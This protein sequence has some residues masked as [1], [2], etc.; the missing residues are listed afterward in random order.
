MFYS[1]TMVSQNA[2]IGPMPVSTVSNST[3]PD[4]CPLKAKGCYA[5]TGPLALHWKK[6]TSGERGDS[7]EDFVQKVRK[8]PHGIWRYAQAGDLPGDGDK[9]DLD[10]LTLLA[11]ANRG[12]PV[13][14]YTHKP[15]TKENVAALAAANDHG[16]HINISC[17]TLDKCDEAITLGFSAAVVVHSQYQRGKNEDLDD[18]KARI[19]AA[20]LRTPAGNKVAICPATYTDT[21][22]LRCGACAKRRAGDT[23]IAFPAHGTR[24]RLVD[25]VL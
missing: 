19:R 11:K 18:Y 5:E 24:K 15:L 21:N 3:C 10:Q 14:C 6:V 7:F 13:V 22:C 2:K 1:L 12:R 23:V 17:E 8:L 4:S 25:E 20:D 16:F 9:I